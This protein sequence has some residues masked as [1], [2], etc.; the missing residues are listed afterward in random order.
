VKV[1]AVRLVLSKIFS[2][3]EIRFHAKSVDSGV[4]K[5]PFEEETILGARKRAIN[6]IGDCDY[7]IGIE[8][9]IFYNRRVKCYYDVQYCAVLDKYGRLTLGHGPG[10]CYPKEIIRVVKKGRSVEEALEELYGVKKI[11]EGVGAI[12]LLSKGLTDRLG[13]TQQAVLMAFVPR[14]HGWEG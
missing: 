7:G 5:Q 10:F 12:G 3:L 1:E 4:G 14:L 11:G 9:G 6:A 2:G 8:A 13:I